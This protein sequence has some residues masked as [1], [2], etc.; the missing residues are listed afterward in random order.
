M[1]IYSIAIIE[2]DKEITGNLTIHQWGFHTM[3]GFRKKVEHKWED[4]RVFSIEGPD[5]LQKRVTVTRLLTIGVFAFAKK[6]AT[7]ESFLFAEKKDGSTLIIKFLKK[8][9]PEVKAIFTPFKSKLPGEN[10]IPSG[11]GSD[12]V[13]QLE[14][15]A[16]LHANGSITSEEFTA[17]KTKILG[18]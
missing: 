1:A 3:T 11:H 12:E 18:L 13:S 16:E 2:G 10:A 14:K 9:E 4:F 5:Q 15:L 7:G 8:S 17:M 6:K